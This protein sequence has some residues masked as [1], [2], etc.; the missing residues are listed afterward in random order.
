MESPASAKRP[1]RACESASRAI[2][3]IVLDRVTSATEEVTRPLSPS[4]SGS[5]QSTS[6]S[7]MGRKVGFGLAAA[8]R[9]GDAAILQEAAHD[10]RLFL[11]LEGGYVLIVGNVGQARV[12]SYVEHCPVDVGRV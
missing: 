8:L 3:A 12:G 2:S 4:G 10:R 6:S 1:P 11:V 5:K 9:L 7:R